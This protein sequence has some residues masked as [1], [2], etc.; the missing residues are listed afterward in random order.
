MDVRPWTMDVVLTFIVHGLTSIVPSSLT[1]HHFILAGEVGLEPTNAGSK[2][3]CLTTWRLPK[4]GFKPR[5]PAGEPSRRGRAPHG[6][7]R[8]SA[9]RTRRPASRLR[10]SDSHARA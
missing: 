5:R 9:S 10:L 4:P 2:D 7:R 6:T 3:R 1:T 8:V